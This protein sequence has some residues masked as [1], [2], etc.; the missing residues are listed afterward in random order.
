MSLFH[1]ALNVE[2]MYYQPPDLNNILMLSI[3]P[4]HRVQ[5]TFLPSDSSPAVIYRNLNWTYSVRQNKLKASKQY[6]YNSVEICVK[7]LFHY[8]L[9]NKTFEMQVSEWTND[10]V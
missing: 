1:A 7:V 8:I 6:E 5:Q 10:E 2:L 4:L 3:S 9:D